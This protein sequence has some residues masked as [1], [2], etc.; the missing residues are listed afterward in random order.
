M[1][2][3]PPGRAPTC[4]AVYVEAAVCVYCQL[5]TTTP[6]TAVTLQNYSGIQQYTSE[7]TVI[8]Q[9]HCGNYIFYPTTQYNKSA[10]YR[11]RSARRPPMR[12]LI[13][14]RLDKKKSVIFYNVQFFYRIFAGIFVAQFSALLH[15]V[16]QKH[17]TTFSTITLTVSV[18]FQ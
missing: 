8:L 15:R 12:T 17:V 9:V 7:T 10:S 6:R 1:S 5:L 11:K 18:R 16:P 2:Q 3:R 14:S 4:L 13:D